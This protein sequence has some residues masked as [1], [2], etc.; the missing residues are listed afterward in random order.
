MIAHARAF[1]RIGMG[2]FSKNGLKPEKPEKYS[3]KSEIFAKEKRSTWFL[4]KQRDRTFVAR[5][6][7]ARKSRKTVCFVDFFVYI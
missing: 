6:R 3:T 2:N 4:E 7:L 1:V 5:G